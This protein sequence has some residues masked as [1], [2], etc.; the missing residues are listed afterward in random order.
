MEFEGIDVEADPAAAEEVKK[1]GIRLVPV[2]TDG[3]RVFHGWNPEGL[4]EFVGI[5]FRED[6]SLPASEL[7][8]LLDQV[9][10]ATQRA[11][12][13]L[14]PDDLLIKVPN[15]N[16]TVRD[17]GY[18][19]FRLSRAYR[20]AFEQQHFP[21][22]WLEET[23]PTEMIDADSLV[24]Y[25]RAVRAGLTDWFDRVGVPSKSVNT[26]YGGQTAHQL[27]DRT[28]WHAAQHLRQIY[29]LLGKGGV[30]LEDPLKEADFEGL[31]LP[32]EVW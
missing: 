27:L 11:L 20:D 25:G 16:R 24:E 10:E 23:P 1:L 17:L 9:L 12:A 8:Q 4:A 32:K 21:E 30:T 29:D 26:Y 15:R 19:I 28:V 6:T 13:P 5:E 31:P 18:H 22:A 7:V 2:V 3:V 14:T